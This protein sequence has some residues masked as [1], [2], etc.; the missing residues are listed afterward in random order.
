MMILRQ[1]TLSS[2]YCNAFFA[3]NEEQASQITMHVH[4]NGVGECGIFTY[5]VAETK[6]SRVM[7]FCTRKPTPTSMCVRKK[8]S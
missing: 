3:M 5:E 6:V 7:D 8:V 2:M 4:T 1:C